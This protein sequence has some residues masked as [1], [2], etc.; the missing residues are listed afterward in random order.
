MDVWLRG[1]PK[2]ERPK[3]FEALQQLVEHAQADAENDAPAT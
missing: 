2:P 3:A 1:V